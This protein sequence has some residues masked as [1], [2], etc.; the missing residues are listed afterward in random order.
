MSQQNN[1][2]RELGAAQVFIRFLKMNKRGAC[3]ASG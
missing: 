2:Q 1:N 3:P